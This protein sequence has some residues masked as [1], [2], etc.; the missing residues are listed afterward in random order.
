MSKIVDPDQLNQSTEVVFVPASKTIQLLEAGNLNDDAP[1]SGSGVALQAVYSFCKEEWR[2]DSGLYLNRYRFPLKAIYEAKYLLQNAWDWAD[3]TTRNLIRDAGWQE[4]NG[5]E[6]ACFISLGSMDDDSVDQAYYT[7]AAGFTETPTPFGSTGG[8]NEGIMI[9]DEGTNDWRGYNKAFLRE[10]LKTFDEYNILV[11]QGYSALTYITYRIPLSNGADASMNDTYDD[12]YI[13][14]ANEPFQ[15]MELQYYPGTGFDSASAK[16]YVQDEVGQDVAGRWFRCSVA[17]TLDAS[18]VTDYTS[19]GG[20]G[21]FVAYEG[22]REVGTGNYYA[23]NRAIVCDSGHKADT[24]QLYAFAQ[25]R[26]RQASDINDDSETLSYGVVNGNVAIRLC[27]FVGSDLHGWDGVCFD[28]FDTNFTDKIKLHDITVDGGGLDSEDV[29]VTSTLRT[30]PFVSAGNMIFNDELVNDADAKYWMYFK[31][32]NSN[33]FDTANA[34]IVKD[35]SG[36][37]I[38]GSISTNSISFDF[39]YAGNTQGGRSGGTDAIVVI[40]AMGLN[41]AEWIEGEFTITE[42]TGLS[43]PVNAGTERNYSNP[44]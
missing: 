39:D 32:A 4:V 13:E 33:D 42:N 26:N 11:E 37:D 5:D 38:T 31:S 10:E 1:R 3:A 30:Y 12:T 15:S 7:T 35:N 44:T 23:F 43:F 20:T 40:V 19:N 9:N 34:I 36:T 8:L 18:G 14:G 21:T 24:E 17:G 27:F 29:P 28:N 25:H 41:G 16:S 6:Y 22:E 2:L